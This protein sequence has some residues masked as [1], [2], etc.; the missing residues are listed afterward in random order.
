M[1]RSRT[2]QI[3][4]CMFR[5]RLKTT[6]TMKRKYVG[7]IILHHLICH[8]IYGSTR[9]V[10]AI[11]LMIILY[12]GPKS[13]GRAPGVHYPNRKDR[14]LERLIE[15][16]PNNPTT[17]FV[18]PVGRKIWMRNIMVRSLTTSSIDSVITATKY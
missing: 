15:N 6:M 13:A 17:K 10:I 12:S 1:C 11:R 14:L 5:T 9:I 7:Y 3:M 16:A 4:L 8:D 2:R 18:P